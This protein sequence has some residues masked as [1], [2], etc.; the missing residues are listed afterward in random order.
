[1]ASLS[2]RPSHLSTIPSITLYDGF[3]VNETLLLK[4]WYCAR[5]PAAGQGKCLGKFPVGKGRYLEKKGGFMEKV[6][7]PPT[8]LLFLTG[9][10][11]P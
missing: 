6:L 4:C 11:H 3:W 10:L 2:I 1:M 9:L 7:H 8:T 5:L